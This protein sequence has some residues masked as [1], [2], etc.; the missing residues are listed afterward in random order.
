MAHHHSQDA[1]LDIEADVTTPLLPTAHD[2]NS[3]N[4]NGDNHI[5]RPLTNSNTNTSAPATSASAP[6]ASATC[7]GHHTC[8]NIER[9]LVTPSHIYTQQLNPSEWL[10]MFEEVARANNWS[11]RSKLDIVPVYLQEGYAPR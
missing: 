1:L 9:H 3:D 2:N 7:C 8:N 4:N 11:A 10:E 5:H 6:A